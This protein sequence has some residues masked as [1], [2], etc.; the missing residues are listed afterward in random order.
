MARKPSKPSRKTKVGLSEGYR[1][2]LETL[3]QARKDA[4]LTQAQLAAR[5]GQSQVFVSRYES[6]KRR[7]DPAEFIGISSAIGANPY[8]LLQKAESDAI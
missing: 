1:A 8:E 3:I 7:L 5:I 4:S 6:G 2:I